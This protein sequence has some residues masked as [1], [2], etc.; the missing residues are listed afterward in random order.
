M[1]VHLVTGQ[2]EACK[3]TTTAQLLFTDEQTN[4]VIKGQVIRKAHWKW[5]GTPEPRMPLG[6]QISAA[7]KK[8]FT[9]FNPEDE[10]IA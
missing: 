7:K 1:Q 4:L 9:S 5:Q 2:T 3:P 8:H 10:V 6:P